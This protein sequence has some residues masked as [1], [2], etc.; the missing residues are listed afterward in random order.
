MVLLKLK[1][2]LLFLHSTR[3]VLAAPVKLRLET[4]FSRLVQRRVLVLGQGKIFLQRVV[5]SFPLVV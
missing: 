1:E 4:D 5:F 2:I 3:G